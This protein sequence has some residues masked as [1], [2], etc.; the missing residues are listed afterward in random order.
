MTD[1]DRQPD[2]E[3]DAACVLCGC[4]TSGPHDPICPWCEGWCP[5]CGERL[6]AFAHRV[7]MR[8][9]VP[10]GEMTVAT[11]VATLAGPPVSAGST[12]LAVGRWETG[13]VHGRAPAGTPG[14]PAQWVP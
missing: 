8:R 1:D 2:A 9:E 5:M 13:R 14:P 3:A 12:A 10:G 4:P 7:Q 6:P 11:A